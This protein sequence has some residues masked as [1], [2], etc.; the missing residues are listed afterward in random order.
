MAVTGLGFCNFTTAVKFGATASTFTIN[1]DTSITATSPAHALGIVDVTVT[2]A[3]G[4]SGTSSGDRFAFDTSGVYEL[5]GFGGFHPNDSSAISNEAYWAGFRIARVAHAWPL[6]TS[7]QQGFTLDGYGGLQPYGPSTP[8]FSQTSGAAGHYWAG[9]DIARDFAFMPD[10]SGG[11][12]LDGLGGLHPFGIN[13]NTAPVPMGYS[14]FG[15][16]VAIRVVIAA[17]GKGGY[18]LDAQGGL[19][20]FGIGGAAPQATP[21]QNT[22]YWTSRLAQDIAL[23]PANGGYTGYV[24]DK[25][26]GLHPFAPNGTA[27]PPAITT[28]YFGFNIARGL[29]FLSGSS[30][31]GYTVDGY[32]GPHPF[33]NAP[34]INNH[35]YWNGYDI[36]IGIFGA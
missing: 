36:V 9:W 1:S 19:H 12:V 26:G 8:A 30:T 31:D 11:L 15:F 21:L 35:S 32:G 24:L 4:T 14:Y 13:G 33:G 28:S 25:F 3:A 5:D 7:S 29:F 34:A 10:G 23:I 20:P 2:N 27:L 6:A 18:T 17:D 16:D 22:G